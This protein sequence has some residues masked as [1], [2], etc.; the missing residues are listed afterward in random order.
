VI[1]S[2]FLG[3][4]FFTLL[5]AWLTARYGRKAQVKIG[6]VEA[7]AATVADVE[8]LLRRA[9]EFR[10]LTVKESLKLLLELD[11]PDGEGGNS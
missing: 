3:P 5:G 9:E 4:P 7:E 1:V 8:A 2:V 6:D 11:S 10:R